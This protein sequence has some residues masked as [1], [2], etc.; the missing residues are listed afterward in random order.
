[1]RIAKET[2]YVLALQLFLI[3]TPALVDGSRGYVSRRDGFVTA[4]G[5]K[6]DGSVTQAIEETASHELADTFA[7]TKDKLPKISSQGKEKESGVVRGGGESYKK[8]RKGKLPDRPF[9]PKA[10]TATKS[11]GGGHPTPPVMPPS[12]SK[13]K[14]P[15]IKTSRKKDEGKVQG[16]PDTVDMGATKAPKGVKGEK[17]HDD[18]TKKDKFNDDKGKYPK[19]LKGGN[20][21]KGGETKVP[22]FSG[23]DDVYDHLGDDG[24]SEGAGAET[25]TPATRA[26]RIQ[27]TMAP[28]EPKDGR[29]DGND[30]VQNASER[31][32]DD[33]DDD[34]DDT[35]SKSKEPVPR[36]SDKLSLT[37]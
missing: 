10:P 32:D 29:N 17:G 3:T 31:D 24:G 28:T 23:D 33:D 14:Y 6:N 19:G 15:E 36:V 1:M 2:V 9:A 27:P 26:P 22:K 7:T 34:D 5:L 20:K 30:N 25:S 12:S 21:D 16:S 8:S 4:R 18:I 37:K 11:P 35:D 13:Q